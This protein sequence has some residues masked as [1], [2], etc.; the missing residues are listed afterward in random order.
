MLVL[1]ET[2]VRKALISLDPVAIVREGLRLHGEGRSTLPKEA[3][4]RWRTRSGAHVRSLVLPARLE[5]S[6]PQQGVKIINASSSNRDHGVPRASGVTCLF[7]GETAQ[8]VCIASAGL[9]SAL[10]TACVTAIA[11]ELLACLPVHKLCLLGAGV[12]A[13]AHL[14]LLLPRMGAPREIAI[15][16]LQPAA[17]LALRKRVLAMTP[18]TRCVL[19]RSAEQAVRGASLIIAV[20]TA[21]EGYIEWE[22]LSAGTLVVNVSLDDLKREIFMRADRLFVDD[23][24]LV[25]ADQ[26]RALG[27]L[28]AEG[29][30]VGPSATAVAGARSVDGELGDVITGRISA[31][32]FPEDM[33]LINPFGCGTSDIALLA[34]VHGVARR[35]R[36]GK[37]VK[38]E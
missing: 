24:E 33:V 7:D 23:W 13:C 15:F 4:L 37:T 25:S 8:I 10:R 3:A 20:T 9:L 22:W 16:D 21:T 11:V 35:Q 30:V 6:D 28:A 1:T 34:A 5:L 26:T 18:Q 27:R 36:L 31:R 17:A 32:I 19:A 38:L 12:L 14:E 29:A 2:D